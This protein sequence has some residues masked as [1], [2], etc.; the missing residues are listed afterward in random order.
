MG[1]QVQASWPEPGLVGVL[2]VGALGIDVATRLEEPAELVP[3]AFVA[4]TLRV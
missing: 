4:V 2:T 1:D 3:T